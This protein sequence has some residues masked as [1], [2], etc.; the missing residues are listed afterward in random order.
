M[1]EVCR[2]YGIIIAM[3]FSD[4][5]PPH[6][7][8]RYDEYKASIQINDLKVIDGFLPPRAL[9]L[10]IEWAFVHR[11]ALLKNWQA[12]SKGKQ[13]KRIKPLG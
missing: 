2:F 6:F 8:A 13:P 1:P 3:F 12:A 4:H 7:H 10:V 5:A 9:G 11:K